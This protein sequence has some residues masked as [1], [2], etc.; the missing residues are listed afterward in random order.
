[1][2]I[3][4]SFQGQQN[5]VTSGLVKLND[6]YFI[7]WIQLPRPHVMG[8]KKGAVKRCME[9]DKLCSHRG[10]FIAVTLSQGMEEDWL[11]TSYY[12]IQWSKQLLEWF[13]QLPSN[14]YENCIKTQ[15]STNT[16][17]LLKDVGG[18]ELKNIWEGIVASMT[19]CRMTAKNT[20][21]INS[22]PTIRTFTGSLLIG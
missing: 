22:A 19:S 16:S 3:L 7:H 10:P 6:L 11:W 13:S 21:S 17:Y 5:T 15:Q 1:M 12:I 14:V 18:S 20:A 4:P 2:L 8:I 9:R